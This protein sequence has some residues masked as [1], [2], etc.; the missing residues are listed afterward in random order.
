VHSAK[1]ISLQIGIPVII[2]V[3]GIFFSCSNDLEK[4]KRITTNPNSPEETSENFHVI[5]TDS[6]RASFELRAKIAETYIDPRRVM[7]FK[8][9]L[10][11]NFFD[12]MGTITSVL[13][14]IYGEVDEESGDIMV[15]DSVEFLNVAK[16]EIL[17]TEVLY[18][19]K[20]G[21]SIYTDKPIVMRGPDKIV[22]G[23][24]ARTNQNMDTLIVHRPQ[25]TIYRNKTNDGNLP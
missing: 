16:Q 19:K 4:V 6:G 11:V 13:T 7:K 21:D 20:E 14:A 17:K 24:G 12:D 5:F 9:G 8:D 18:W 10:M 25:A 22:T 15:K 23:I 3:A 1:Y 2:L